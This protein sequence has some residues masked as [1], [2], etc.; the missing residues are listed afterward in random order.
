PGKPGQPAPRSEQQRFE[1]A[2]GRTWASFPQGTELRELIRTTIGGK[3]Y[4]LFGFRSGKTLCL[5]LRAA[6]LGH[7]TEP[8]CTPVSTLAHTASPIV[9]VNSDFGFQDRHAQGSAE[10]SFGI[11]ADGVS[12]VDVHAVDGMHQAII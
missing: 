4:V 8:A 2:N 1:A 9:V 6:S 10:F 5:R 7:T 12:R 11:A 3:T